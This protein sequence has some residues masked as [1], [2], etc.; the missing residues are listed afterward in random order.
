[1][2]TAWAL[3]S[4]LYKRE[5]SALEV[6]TKSVEEDQIGSIYP[7]TIRPNSYWE[8]R[9]EEIKEVNINIFQKSGESVMICIRNKYVDQKTFHGNTGE[10][11]DVEGNVILHMYK[12]ELH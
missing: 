12:I 8:K 2:T 6:L 11:S 9:T 10:W 3:A 7:F 1:M 4:A 5:V